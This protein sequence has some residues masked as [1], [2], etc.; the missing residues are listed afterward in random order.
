MTVD[1]AFRICWVAL[2]LFWAAQLLRDVRALLKGTRPVYPG[3]YTTGARLAASSL[4]FALSFVVRGLVLR[5][6]LLAAS[7][8]V[9]C[10]HFALLRRRAA[11]SRGRR[12]S[13]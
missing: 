9:L 5:W 10:F 2:A 6:A 13:R 7:T 11:P 4:L 1:S 12:T 3:Q 8:G